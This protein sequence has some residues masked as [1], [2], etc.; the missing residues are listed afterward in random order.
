LIKEGIL[1]PV[2]DR[3]RHFR[4][5]DLSAPEKHK[6]THSPPGKSKRQGKA[7]SAATMQKGNPNSTAGK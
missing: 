6:A 3:K 5:T 2:P 4:I 7:K 1:E